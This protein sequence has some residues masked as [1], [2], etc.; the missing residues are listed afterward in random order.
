MIRSQNLGQAEEKGVKRIAKEK[1]FYYLRSSRK[2]EWY[3]KWAFPSK[4]RICKQISSNGMRNQTAFGF[5]YA[6][7]LYNKKAK[8]PY[9]RNWKIDGELSNSKMC[10]CS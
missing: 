6:L 9:G 1:V 7:Y 2:W 8:D 3:E 4:D 5:S 10:P